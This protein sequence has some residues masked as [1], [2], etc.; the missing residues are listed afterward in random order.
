MLKEGWYD[1]LAG[2]H[3]KLADTR[4]KPRH[5]SR[6]KMLAHAFA[7]KTVVALEPLL[8]ETIESLQ[9]LLDGHIS[10]GK[11]DNLHRVLNYFTIDLFSNILYGAKLGCLERGDDMLIAESKDGVLYKAPFSDPLLNATVLNLV[12]AFNPWCLRL[13]SWLA[14]YHP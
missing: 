13:S 8:Q 7:A 9:A 10:S 5:Q 2:T 11:E 12:L 1:A 14:K 3:R 4:D 6:R